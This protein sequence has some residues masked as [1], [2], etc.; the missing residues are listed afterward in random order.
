MHVVSRQRRRARLPVRLPPR[1]LAFRP[2]VGGVLTDR[3]AIER[4]TL[5]AAMGAAGR[6]RSHPSAGRCLAL[7]VLTQHV[8]AR[9]LMRERTLDPWAVGSDRPSGPAF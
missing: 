7:P 8:S 5:L 6:A 3:A 1:V 9:N 4:I 2:A